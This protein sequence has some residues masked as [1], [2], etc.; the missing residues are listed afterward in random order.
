MKLVQRFLALA[1]LPFASGRLLLRSNG[2]Q[3]GSLALE[4][5]PREL[6]PTQYYGL[7][8]VGTPAQELRVVFDTTTGQLVV[9]SSKCTDLPCDPHRRYSADNSSTSMQ[10]GWADEPTK[11]ISGTDDRDVKAVS[12]MGA[13]AAGEF[14]RDRVCVGAK[15]SQHCGVADFISLTEETDDQFA[16]ADFD[17]V[18][19]LA[20]TSADAQQ[21]NVLMNLAKKGEQ[22]PVSPVFSVYLSEDGSGEL[23]VGGYDPKRAAGAFVWTPVAD[24]GTWNF[25]V[26]DISVGGQPTGLCGS[27]GCLAVVDTAAS[28]IGVPNSIMQAFLAH[29]KDADC[30]SQ[31]PS[32]GFHVNGHW[33]ELKGE[34]YME[35]KGS[36]CGVLLNTAQSSG[37]HSP[38]LFLGYPFLRRYYTVFDAQK[39]R[40]GMAVSD[41]SHVTSTTGPAVSVPLVGVRP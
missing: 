38:L 17:G 29:T 15:D 10:I 13:D 22:K 35:R 2:A 14:V 39:N 37:E 20:P 18:L 23:Q 34:E 8:H 40:V 28:L 27:K 7:V 12:L 19:G 31:L 5:S 6:P 9:P 32:L 30:S 3:F 25:V 4:A 24:A 1:L 33:L 21:F 36:D 26:D 16:D 11:A 41:H